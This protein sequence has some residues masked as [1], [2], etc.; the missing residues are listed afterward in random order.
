[1]HFEKAKQ[2]L[3]QDKGKK[4][5]DKEIEQIIQLLELFKDVWIANLLKSTENEKCDSLC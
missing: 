4:Y 2:I 1:M 3:N 5:T